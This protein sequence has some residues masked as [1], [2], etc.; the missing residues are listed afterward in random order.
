[1]TDRQRVDK[2]NELRKLKYGVFNMYDLGENITE[3]GKNRFSLKEH[4]F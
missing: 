2:T 3:T 1:M 4:L